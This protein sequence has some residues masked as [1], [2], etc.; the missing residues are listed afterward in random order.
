MA[1][2]NVELR[3]NSSQA[4]RALKVVDGQAKKFNTTV[5]KS[6]GAL[7]QGQINLFGF[8]KGAKAAGVGAAAATPAVAGLGVAVATALG[9]IAA[10]GGAVAFFGAAV[11]TLSDQDFAEAKLKSLK[12]DTDALVPSLKEVSKELDYSVSTTELTAAAYDVASAG[13]TDAS[14]AA[15]ILKVSV[16]GARGGF[17]DLDTAASATVK[18]INAFGATADEAEE[19]MNKFVQTQ[20]DGI[21]TVDTYAKN[22][23]KVAPVASMMGIKL[24]EV[25]AVIAQSTANGVNA[26]VAFTGLKTALL[27][28]GGE[29]GGKKLEK[30]GIDISAATL[31]SEGLLANLQKLEGLDVK[32]IEQIFGQEAIQ[33]MSPVL[34]N[35]EKFEKLLLNQKNAAAVAAKAHEIA[36]DTIQ[37]KWTRISNIMSNMFADQTVLGAALKATLDGLGNAL[38]K[39]INLFENLAKAVAFI[40]E[41]IKDFHREVKALTMDMPDWLKN[42]TGLGT[43][44][45][46]GDAFKESLELEKQKTK[47]IKEAAEAIVKTNKELEKQLPKLDPIVTETDKIKEQWKSVGDTIKSDVTNSIKGAIK[48]SQT[49]GQSMSNI[50]SSIADKAM[51]VALN[52]ALWGSI[53]GGG[54]GG[55]LGG[56]FSGIFGGN[57][58]TKANGGPVS[59]KTP[60]M[61]GERGPEIFV[62]NSSGKIISNNRIGGGGATVNVTVNATESNVSASGGEAKQL[63]LAIASAVQQQLVKER[64]PGGLLA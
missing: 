26:E 53:G 1:Q 37:A 24:E 14:D 35:L 64:R 59:S 28:L 23:G 48:G 36:N 4:V 54:T 21:I 63:G 19:L 10:I 11:K 7:K 42:V 17:S 62:P 5:E 56:V 15:K 9:P 44:F 43:A 29:A 25:N 38:L 41:K 46:S 34:N 31:E 61:V 20:N 45:E 8:G 3:I 58:K 40:V 49:L 22:I 52:M 60:Y 2:S 55:L 57:K 39:I 16:M 30:L 12:V 50:L 6:G 51:D 32:A 27:R 33:V 47:E 13:F 18:V